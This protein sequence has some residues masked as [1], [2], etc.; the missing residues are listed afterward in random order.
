MSL[1]VHGQTAA[2]ADAAEEG[3]IDVALVVGQEHRASAQVF[4]EFEVGWIAGRGF[5]PAPISRCRWC[6]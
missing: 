6:C 5:T 2:L 4:G 3:Q 1:S